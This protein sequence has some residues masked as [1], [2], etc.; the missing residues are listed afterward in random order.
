MIV[1]RSLKAVDLP[2]LTEIIQKKWAPPE[3][4]R[5]QQ[6]AGWFGYLVMHFFSLKQNCSWVAVDEDT[7]KTVGVLL[8]QIINRSAGNTAETG[9]GNSDLWER[10][11]IVDSCADAL[12]ERGFGAVDPMEAFEDNARVM[13]EAFGERKPDAELLLFALDEDYRGH[14]IGRELFDR[15][16]RSLE[17]EGV[18]DFYLHSDSSSAFTFYEHR[19]IRQIARMSSN[20]RMGDV[21]NVE[22]YLYEGTVAEQLKYMNDR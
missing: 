10:R 20:L 13:H 9:S 8:T 16:I 4:R 5:H 22:L 17:E 2:D 3:L 15:T 12:K 1:Y 7:G 11:M 18:S 14:G 19:G 6:L 21:E